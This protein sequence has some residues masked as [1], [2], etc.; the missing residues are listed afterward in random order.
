MNKDKLMNY[1][2]AQLIDMLVK[3]TAVSITTPNDALAQILNELERIKFRETECFVCVTLDGSHKIIG[4]HIVSQGLVDRTLVHPR[5]VFRP[6]IMDNAAA[7]II[8][9]NHPSG[10]LVP[11]AEDKEV[12]KR[13]KQAG[14]IIGIEVVDHLI[15]APSLTGY[16]SFR[17]HTIF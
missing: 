14:D 16:F 12:T 3:E 4:V 17:E 7:I 11:S 13:M 2:K 8:A 9:H 15:I 5:E 1:S 6:A 10:S